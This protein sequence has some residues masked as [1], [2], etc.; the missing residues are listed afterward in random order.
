[1]QK[2][3]LIDYMSKNETFASGKLTGSAYKDAKE[4]H[5]NNVMTLVGKCGPMKNLKQCISVQQIQLSILD[6][7]KLN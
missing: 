2:N 6:E 4:K 1:M 3:V 7:V 5:W